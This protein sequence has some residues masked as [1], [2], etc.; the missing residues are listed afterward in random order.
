MTAKTSLESA[1][2]THEVAGKTRRQVYDAIVEAGRIGRT[3]RELQERLHMDGSTERP[4]RLELQRAG[5]IEAAPHPRLHA[6][7]RKSVVWRQIT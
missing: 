7:G 5:L 6:N 3:D 2:Q 1:N 4:R